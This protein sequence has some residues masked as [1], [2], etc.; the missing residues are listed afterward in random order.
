MGSGEHL[1]T[2]ERNDFLYDVSVLGKLLYTFYVSS[3]E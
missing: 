3:L 1:T 2:F